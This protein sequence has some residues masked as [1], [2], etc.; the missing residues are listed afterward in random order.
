MEGTSASVVAYVDPC[1]PF[2]WITWQW[3]T[4]LERLDRASLEVRLLSLAAVNEHRSLD[5]WYRRFNDAAWAPARV[6]AAAGE[7]SS[8]EGARRFYEAFGHRFHVVHGT[9]DEV[10]RVA[11]AAQSLVD[12]GLP[13]TL[14][15]AASDQRWDP[16]FRT[17]T[18]SAIDAVG[19]DVGVPVIEIDGVSCSGPV[20]SSVPRGEEAVALLDAVRT[21]AHQHGFMRIERPRHGELQPV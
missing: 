13:P 6:M 12:A 11:L 8:D 15:A 10:D 18:R 1:C 4:E 9:A 3:L 14:I 19:L 16:M 21:L 5:A 17:I 20:L 7:K 2:A